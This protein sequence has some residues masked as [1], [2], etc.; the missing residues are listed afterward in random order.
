MTEDLVDVVGDVGADS[1]GQVRRQGPRCGRPHEEPQGAVGQC[2]LV[3]GAGRRVEGE[4]H[5]DGG[6]DAGPVGV[7]LAGLEVRQRGLALP[8]EGQDALALVGQVLVPQR[9]EGPHDALHVGEVHGL[10]GVF[11]VDPAGLAGDVALPAVGGAL[12]EGAAEVVEPVDAEID[13]IGPTPQFELFLGQH[14][15]REP[16]AVPPEA[17][18]HPA[19]PHRLVAGHGVLH[20]AGEEMAVVGEPVGERRPVVKDVLV[21]PPGPGGHRG[22]EGAVFGPEGQH[23]VFEERVVGLLVDLGVGGLGA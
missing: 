20:E 16:V 18:L 13:D 7:V 8:T 15:G 12:D 22:G 1:Q 19:A 3:T 6:V 14:L 2:R 4:G 10:V 9:L 17:P 11:E 23:P 5:G 21:V